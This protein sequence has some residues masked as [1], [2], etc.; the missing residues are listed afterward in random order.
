MMKQTGSSA[1]G[2]ETRG[3]VGT[4]I[5]RG[6]AGWVAGM[7]WTKQEGGTGFLP[8]FLS[9]LRLKET[10]F[11]NSG[12]GDERVTG[13]ISPGTVR[14]VRKFYSLAAAF[15]HGIGGSSYGIY[16]IDDNNWVFL[17]TVNGRMTVM[18]DV[19]G[20]LND[21][22][23]A[24]SRFLNFNEPGDM[25]WNCVARPEENI[26]CDVLINGLPSR[27][28]AKVRLHAVSPVR[29]V[30]LLAGLAV[31]VAGGMWIKVAHDRFASDAAFR[32]AMNSKPAEASNVPAKPA[33]PHPWATQFVLPAFISQCWSTRAPVY[34]SV[35]GW[36]ESA[37]VCDEHT[38]RLHYVAT[39][40]S[41]VEDFD[42]R[43]RELFG[44][45]ASFNLKEGGKE[46]DVVFPF[47]LPDAHALRDEPVASADEQLKRFI[48]HLQRWNVPVQFTEV[49]APEA[50]PGARTETLAQD[51]REFTF[52]L[53]SRLAAEWLLYGLDDT[54]IRLSA[55]A[56]TVS[57]K[58]QYDYTIRG[59]LYAKK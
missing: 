56:F 18:A 8:G 5:S 32:E 42:R 20:T 38:L 48:S 1:F 33:L 31:V 11:L 26:S 29:P 45:S 19:V 22:R 43:V 14:H 49:I 2:T 55:I 28:R 37:G 21:V 17:A 46:G 34:L 3:T 6:K 7:R 51:W 24:E 41:T 40:G 44:R 36:R 23:V 39:P 30:L 25:G 54:G 12:T 59:S 47:G 16:R 15:L 13:L 50:A 10:W 4:V 35:A 58:G 9:R 52:T 27:K 57:P 53:S